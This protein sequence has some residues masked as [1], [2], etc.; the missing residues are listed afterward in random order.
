MEKAVTD[1]KLAF[2]RSDAVSK[3]VDWMSL[4]IPNDADI[5]KSNLEDFENEKSIPPAL[6]Y[7]NDTNY[8]NSRYNASISWIAEHHHA[9][10][11]NGPYYLDSYS[12]E[13]RKITI[14]A[15]VD[16]TYPFKAGYWKKFEDVSM[17]KIENVQVP[18]DI[19]I[20][21]RLDIP[22]LVTPNA[23][24]YYYFTNSHGAVIDEGKQISENGSMKITLAPEKTMNFDLGSNDL[25][26]FVVSDSA[27]KPDMFQSSFLVTSGENQIPVDG[28]I[29]RSEPLAVNY[30]YFASVIALA[31]LVSGVM[32]YIML[33]RRQVK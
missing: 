3:N 6:A 16:S 26:M 25:Q 32:I 4:I 10:I 9:V 31:G 1:G 21:T 17:P 20:G 13:A 22:V 33:R 30:A 5:I 29:Q 14:D 15:F 19:Q 27:Y 12:P 23:T 11:S 7:I 28:L 2:S 8:F 18:T 24:V